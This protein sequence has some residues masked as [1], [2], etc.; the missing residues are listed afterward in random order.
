LNQS[1]FIAALKKM[2]EQMMLSVHRLGENTIAL[3]KLM[4]RI[5]LLRLPSGVSSYG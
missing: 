4:G 5:P 3:F 2:T 1:S